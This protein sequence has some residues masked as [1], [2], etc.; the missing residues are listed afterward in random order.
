[1]LL[2]VV[3]RLAPP[4]TATRVVPLRCAYGLGSM[5][6]ASGWN[7]VRRRT[8]AVCEVRLPDAV[9]LTLL[10]PGERNGA[11][12]SRSVVDSPTRM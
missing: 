5:M 11:L 12:C 6:F 7:S 1:M 9:I 2:R 3:P 10:C 8:T 4:A